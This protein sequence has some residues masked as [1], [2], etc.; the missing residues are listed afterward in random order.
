MAPV[1]PV[2]RST[3]KWVLH[4]PAQAPHQALHMPEKTIRVDQWAEKVL[5][6]KKYVTLQDD[7]NKYSDTQENRSKWPI[8][9]S[10]CDTHKTCT[11]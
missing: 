6:T 3:Q 1:M 4:R 9:Y 8:N 10:G 2:M 11:L 5:E 7:E